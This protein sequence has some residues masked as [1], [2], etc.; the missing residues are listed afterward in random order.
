AQALT[1]LLDK[2]A[3]QTALD[4]F[5]PRLQGRYLA[6]MQAKLGLD[7]TDNAATQAGDEALIA[8]L[9]QLLQAQRLDYT[10]FLR[11]L[12]EFVATGESNSWLLQGGDQAAIE[13][14]L[15]DY[16]QHINHQQVNRQHSGSLPDPDRAARMRQ[17]NPKFVLRNY[18]AQQVIDAA[19]DGDTQPLDQLLQVLRDPYA[20]HPQWVEFANPAP[21]WAAG[22]SVSCSS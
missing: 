20:E 8:T 6:L 13:G 10:R 21:A 3:L 2:E 22:L 1:P 5:E 17:H 15:V 18:L 7:A 9:L 16:R 11:G 14:W 19:K 4:R 12:C